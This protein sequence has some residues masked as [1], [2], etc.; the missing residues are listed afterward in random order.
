HT[1]TSTHTHA[2]THTHTH[3]AQ[4]MSALCCPRRRC[5]GRISF[6][7]HREHKLHKN[8]HTHTHKHTHTHTHTHMQVT[9]THATYTHTHTHTHGK[10]RGPSLVTDILKRLHKA[11]KIKG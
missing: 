7:P 1:H 3:C 8:T 11:E 2:H 10:Y 9:H 6:H 4:V 5:K